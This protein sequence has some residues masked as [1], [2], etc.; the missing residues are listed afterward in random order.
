MTVTH[1]T[2]TPDPGRLI[3]ADGDWWF[4]G[5]GGIARLRPG[6]VGPDGALLPHAERWLEKAGLREP[7]TLRSYSLTVLTSTS[8]NLGCGYCF[9]NTGQDASGGSRP[10]RIKTVRLTSET[11]GRVLEFTRRRMAEARLERLALMLFG[12]EPLLNLRG[13][14]EL[15]ERAAGL[16]PVYAAMVSNGV[17][18]TPLVARELGAAGLR[19]VQVTFDGDR[20]DHDAIR[21]RRSG[22]GTFDTIV[23]NLS[24]AMDVP[25]LRWDLRVNV[26]HHNRHGMDDLLDRLS[27]R[28]DPTRCGLRFALVGDVGVGY[29]NELAYDTGL[30]ADFVRWYA[31][32]LALGFAVTRPRSAAGCQACSI[33]DGRYGAVVNAD[34]VLSSCWETAGRPG[35][36][37]GTLEEGYYPPERTE[38]LWVTCEDQ[39]RHGA[40]AG[41]L[42]AFRDA[43]DAALLDRLHA[44]GRI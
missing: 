24:R 10:P 35:W 40:E 1:E 6:H 17:L 33:R 23:D 36:E 11:I 30:A 44:A 9:Q 16:G 29:G 15:L 19:S 25:E 20:A 39:Y 12:G 37:V 3:R 41:R 28:L 31:R 4:L 32:A 43:V 22:G 13:C 26:S 34:G 18:L 21:V 7:K 38:G 2:P 42:D 14:R 27:E 5:S 8:C